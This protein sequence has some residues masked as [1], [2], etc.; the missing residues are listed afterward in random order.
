MKTLVL[1]LAL[2]GLHLTQTFAQTT[3]A[4][5]AAI[6]QVHDD[7]L[8][9]FDKRDIMAVGS[10]FVQSPDLYYQVAP[11]GGVMIVARGYD[12]MVKM[13]GSRM[14]DLANVP[15][16]KNTVTQYVAHISGNSAWV[17]FTLTDELPD[18]QKINA[19]QFSVLE[20]KSDN[21]SAPRWKIAA[22]TWQDY[23]D[24]KLIEVK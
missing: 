1:L 4:D 5:E 9:A 21:V 11:G 6:R 24:G 14:K 22:M 15:P 13:I 20:K 7:M 23:P 17:T 3:Q 2:S 10:Q 8:M 18:G 19:C 16:T 12:N